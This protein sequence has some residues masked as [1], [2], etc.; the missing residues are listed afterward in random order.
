[1]KHVCGFLLL[2]AG[3]VFAQTPAKLEFEVASIR[4]AGPIEAMAASGKFHVG[5]HIDGARVDIGSMALVDLIQIAYKTKRYQISGTDSLGTQRFDIIAK[6]PEGANKDQVPEMLQALLADRFKLAIHRDT[7]DQSVYA[8]VVAK[9]GLKMKE[10]PPDPEPSTSDDPSAPKAGDPPVKMQVEQ[11][12]GAVITGGATGTTKVAMGQNGTMHF[13][14]Q[15]MQI[16]GL[17]EFLSR[18]VERPVIDMTDLKGNYQVALDLSMDEMRSI[19][20]SAGV[21][22]PGGGGA[23]ADPGKGPADLASEPTGSIFSSIQQ[24]GLKLEARKAPL[25]LIVIDHVEKTP[26]EN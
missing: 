9:G 26:T 12:K 11:G 14:M 21:A 10:S 18:F 25:E 20:R 17:A 3:A 23:A 15:K 5:M 13:E 19:A 6:L 4:P 16:A 1:M 8:L 2:A 7:K 22:I 24:L